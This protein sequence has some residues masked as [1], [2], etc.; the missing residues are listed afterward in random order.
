[1]NRTGKQ[2]DSPKVGK[3]S[4]NLGHKITKKINSAIQQ[5]VKV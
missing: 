3:K 5:E 1:M 4:T 2:G